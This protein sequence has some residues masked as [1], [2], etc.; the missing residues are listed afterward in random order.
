MKKKIFL[1]LGL[2]IFCLNLAQAQTHFGFSGQVGI[3]TNNF[4]ENT[5]AVGGGFNFNAYFPF[6]PKVPI[7]LGINFG[8]MLYGVNQQRLVDNLE[9]KAGNIVLDRIPVDFNI[10]TN[11]NLINGLVSLRF[12]APLQT[13]QPYLEGAV[14]FNYLYTRTK[15]IDNTGRFTVNNNNNTTNNNNVINARTQ[16]NSWVL[17]YGGGG[18][19][20]IN[21]GGSAFL[22]LRVLYLIG[23][24]ADYY[25]RSQTQN[26]TLTFGGSNYNRQT[27]SDITA[28][29]DGIPKS[30]TTD[31]F[32]GNIGLTFQINR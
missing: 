13:I 29:G 17:S 14:G 18:G 8:Y 3:P 32:M 9:V 19:F 1:V 4:R 27:P 5:N 6:S 11:N 25:D 24:R 2:L 15:I 26:W 30:S 21:L 7:F 23:G 16:I 10:N 22:D 28:Q 12:K 31:M 20:M